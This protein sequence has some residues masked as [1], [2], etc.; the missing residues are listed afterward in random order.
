V[1]ERNGE[2]TMKKDR[3]QD[4]DPPDE[5]SQAERIEQLKNR[6]AE[7]SGGTIS[8]PDGATMDPDL[9][10]EFLKNVV[11]VE[12]AGWTRPAD[13]LAAG[14]LE[15]T[16]PD[17][18]DDQELGARLRDV[19]HAMALR[20][21]YVMSTD[22]LSDRELYAELVEH[23]HEE[24]MMGPAT[25]T[26]GFNFVID[27]VSS[28]SD[29]DTTLYLKYYAD[30]DYRRRWHEDYPEDE[31][32]EKVEPPYDRD[33]FLPQPDWTPPDSGDDEPLM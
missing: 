1:R 6:V 18:L 33:R 10:E 8:T 4:A 28:G 26:A 24:T 16:P 12:E 13:H 27:L 31:M 30:D 21:M 3:E 20:N 32:P 2:Q 14:G 11:A 5:P 22:H 19:I 17:R 29:E 23:L 15:L 25:P 9:E 7:L